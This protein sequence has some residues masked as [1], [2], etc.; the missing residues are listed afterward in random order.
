MFTLWTYCKS[1]D[2]HKGFKTDHQIGKK[3]RNL[4]CGLFGRYFDY[5]II[6]RTDDSTRVL[7]NFR[8]AKAGFH[9]KQREIFANT[10]S[11]SRLFRLPDK[12]KDDVSKTSKIQDQRFDNRMQKDK[13]KTSSSHLKTCIA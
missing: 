9:N 4:S 8:P 11:G 3:Q 13:D 2:I 1:K 6:Q 7:P 10:F 12:F 5:C